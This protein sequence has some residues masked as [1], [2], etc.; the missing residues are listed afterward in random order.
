MTLGPK[1]GSPRVTCFMF[2]YNTLETFVLDNKRLKVLIF[3]NGTL[4][5]CGSVVK[6]TPSWRSQRLCGFYCSSTLPLGAVGW[7]AECD[8]AFPGH[9]PFFTSTCIVKT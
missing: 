8:S 6:M 1:W 7:P 5:S 3:P 4:P 2:I 9:A